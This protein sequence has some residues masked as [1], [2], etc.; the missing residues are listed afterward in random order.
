MDS[1]KMRV[2]SLLL[3]PTTNLCDLPQEIVLSILCYLGPIDLIT[4]V[5]P[6]CRD[7]YWLVKEEVA[8]GRGVHKITLDV[9]NRCIRVITKFK[10]VLHFRRDDA[11]EKGGIPENGIVHSR[12]FYVHSFTF[13]RDFLLSLK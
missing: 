5:M 11:R 2:G 1:A 7:W 4:G 9:K 12:H 10:F 3:R 6:V 13:T 8:R